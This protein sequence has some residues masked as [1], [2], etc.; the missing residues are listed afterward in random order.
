MIKKTFRLWIFGLLL[1]ASA[2]A[3]NHTQLVA[4]YQYYFDTDPGVGIA[5]NGAIVPITPTANFNQ[6]V[7]I[8]TPAL[9]AG[10]HTLYV[11][12]G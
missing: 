7:A 1:A 6:T 8:T 11:R 10:L 5:G 3:Q 2:S 4:A 9:S 12:A